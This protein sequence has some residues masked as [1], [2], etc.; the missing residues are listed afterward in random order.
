MVKLFKIGITLLMLGAIIISPF[1]TCYECS[2]SCVGCGF[3]RPYCAGLSMTGVMLMLIGC[4]LML[5]S[6]SL[7][8]EERRS[9]VNG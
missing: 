8:K 7:S 9:D 5:L 4:L 2:T 3:T 6:M 1:N